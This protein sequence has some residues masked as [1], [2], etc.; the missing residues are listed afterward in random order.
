M[1]LAELSALTGI[2]P[3]IIKRYILER[4]LSPPVGKTRAAVY[5][6]EHRREL[7]RIRALHMS[8]W[9]LDEIRD[10][11]RRGPRN[12]KLNHLKSNAAWIVEHRIV[13][14]PGISLLFDSRVPYQQ[15][16]MDEIATR[17]RRSLESLNL[18]LFAEAKA[19]IG[20]VGRRRTGDPAPPEEQVRQLSEG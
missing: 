18:P 17:T 1:N 3:R 7:I 15:A 13:L 20:G 2:S 8:G 4:L 5:N 16:Q 6:D 12:A 10:E 9:K 19:P 11:V 14:A